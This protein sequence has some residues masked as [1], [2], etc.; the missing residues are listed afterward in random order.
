MKSVSLGK[1]EWVEKSCK[2][3]SLWKV[4]IREEREDDLEMEIKRMI[5][6][7]MTEKCCLV[8][9]ISECNVKINSWESF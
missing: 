7:N 3:T 8:D 4:P 2:E 5:G 9:Q 6:R 1:T